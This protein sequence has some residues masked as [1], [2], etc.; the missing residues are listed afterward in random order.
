[1]RQLLR[2]NRFLLKIRQSENS[3]VVV[4]ALI[5]TLLGLAVRIG[6]L[7]LAGNRPISPLSGTGDQVRYLTLAD[8]LF[9]GRGLTYCGQ[10]TA[11]RGPLY[12]LLLA[13][14]HLAFGS[15]YLVA[16]RIF[17]FLL[18]LGVAYVCYLLAEKLFCAEAGAI[19]GTLALTLPTLIFISTELQTEQLAAFLTVLFLF[20]LV[21]EVRA[22]NSDTI[23]MGVTSGLAAL[24]RFNCAILAVI[25]AIVCLWSR[26]SLRD[27]SVLC[28]V[29]CLVVTP[30]IVRN[31]EVFHGRVLFSSVG[32][33]TLLIGVVAPEGRAQSADGERVRAAVGWL[34]TDIEVNDPHRLL[35]GSEEQLDRQARRAAIE[36]WKGLSWRSRVNLLATKIN[37]FLLSKDQFLNTSSFSVTPFTN[38]FRSMRQT[39]LLL[40]SFQLLN[41]SVLNPLHQVAAAFNPDSKATV[42]SPT[43]S[44]QSCIVTSASTAKQSRSNRTLATQVQDLIR[45]AVDPGPASKP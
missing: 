35:F 13:G 26:R 14:S 4:I 32:G 42:V 34:H 27:A 3:A 45:M 10:P 22:G 6:L 40:F 5:I 2:L 1:M 20:F 7:F 15:D 21:Q 28:L 11:I 25:G 12:P 43:T 36:V 41:I 29:S 31:L 39:S 24:V 23:G 18:G 19:A 17:Q 8:S 16:V 38:V 37:T 30:W 33:M 9:H 44:R